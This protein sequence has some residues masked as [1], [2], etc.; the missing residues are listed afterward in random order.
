MNTKL[1]Y[2][3]LSKRWRDL[4]IALA[5]PIMILNS[6]MDYYYGWEARKQVI[7]EDYKLKW[8][9]LSHNHTE[10]FP[11]ET[12]IDVDG[13]P[14]FFEEGGGEVDLDKLREKGFG[15]MIPSPTDSFTPEAKVDSY[16]SKIFQ[17]IKNQVDRFSNWWRDLFK[18]EMIKDMRG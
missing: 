12:I 8:F 3:K 4:T 14:I 7:Q 17:P 10:Y 5:L 2:K 18:E 11:S 1:S 9:I 6:V 16:L 13:N 15:D